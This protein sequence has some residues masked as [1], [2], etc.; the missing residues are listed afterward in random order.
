MTTARR[1]RRPRTARDVGA[2]RSPAFYAPG[3]GDGGWRAW[4]SLLHPPYTAW[5][6]SY[7]AIG[8][9]LAHPIRLDRLGWSL[10]GFFLAMGVGAHALDEVHGHPLRTG[11]PDWWLRAVAVAA[12]TGAVADGWLVGGLHLVPFMVVG[13]VLVLGYNLEW[14]GG[15]L[16]NTAGF[17]AAWGAFP[18]LT[19]YF[20]QHW[21][22]SPASWIAA[23]AAFG[24]SVAQRTLSTPARW[25]RRSLADVTAV[26][27]HPDGTTQHLSSSELLRPLEVALRVMSWS[28]V[29]LAVALVVAAR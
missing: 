19:G 16:H 6:L 11:L 24:L 26:A 20:V 23:L 13:V 4:L 22:L 25:I 5:H 17:G 18:L 10:L 27:E 7:V 1:V 2:R 21:M 12:V 29:V 14:F 9:A 3:A 15:V 8:A 28:M